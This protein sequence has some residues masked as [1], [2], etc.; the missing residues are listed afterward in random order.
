MLHSRR[1]Q[2]GH[3]ARRL[4]SLIIPGMWP[5]R[6]SWCRLLVPGS[7]GAYCRHRARSLDF[8]SESVGASSAPEAVGLINTGRLPLKVSSFAINGT[9]A[10]EFKIASGT[11]CPVGGGSVG[12]YASCSVNVVFAPTS[13]GA[14]SAYSF[15]SR[16]ML[17][18]RHRAVAL[19]GTGINSP[20]LVVAPTNL[21]F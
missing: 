7:S 21:G 3:S 18:A 2:W 19:S 12:V 10:S 20:S 15:R 17:R 13:T 1:K 16:T 9:N 11:T 5:R 8:G 4:R 6:L 14:K